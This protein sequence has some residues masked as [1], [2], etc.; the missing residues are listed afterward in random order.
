LTPPGTGPYR[1]ATHGG[2]TLSLVRNEF[3]DQ[4]SAT[5]QP[6]GLLD[7]YF[8]EVLRTLGYQV[9]VRRRAPTERNVRL[10]DPRA[11]IQVEA[12]GWTATLPLPPSFYEIVACGA[13]VANLLGYCNRNLDRRAAASTAML[14]RERGEALRAWTSIDRELTL[15]APSC[16]WPPVSTGGSPR[17]GSATTRTA[18]TASAL[19]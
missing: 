7:T 15:E 16:R 5:A 18:R 2:E 12:G 14:Q 17:S 10:N 13:H 19:C 4:W 8:A 3:F 11:G 6:D 1:I 9:T